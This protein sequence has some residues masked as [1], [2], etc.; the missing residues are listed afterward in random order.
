[1]NASLSEDYEWTERVVK[2]LRARVVLLR[3]TTEDTFVSRR[4]AVPRILGRV[5]ELVVHV[6]V[7]MYN[8]TQNGGK[9]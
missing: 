8:I 3:Q 7:Y 6:Y 9:K 4:R 2:R 1:M 5:R